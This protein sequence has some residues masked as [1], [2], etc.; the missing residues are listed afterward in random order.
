MAFCSGRSPFSMPPYHAD[1]LT[2]FP[3]G[4]DPE[5]YWGAAERAER[6]AQAAIDVQRAWRST[7][8]PWDVIQYAEWA[9][10]PSMTRAR[11]PA[12]PL[13]PIAL[14][15]CEPEKQWQVRRLFKE[16]CKLARQ[17]GMGMLNEVSEKL[18]VTYGLTVTF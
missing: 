14:Y 8:T 17:Y 12:R 5:P 3:S 18:V 10:D 2:A 9:L 7:R 4:A 16:A 11:G 1:P 13:R 15:E 6:R